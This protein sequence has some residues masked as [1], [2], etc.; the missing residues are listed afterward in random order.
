VVCFFNSVNI[1]N[2]RGDR[3]SIECNDN[4]RVNASTDQ[5]VCASPLIL[6]TE[7][8][9]MCS[10]HGHL[11]IFEQVCDLN[12]L[13]LTAA[14]IIR[15]PQIEIFFFFALQDGKWTEF[16]SFLE[17]E[18]SVA[19]GHHGRLECVCG[20]VFTGFNCDKPCSGHG[21]LR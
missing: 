18:T 21:V 1:T 15:F 2:W 9:V 20:E 13:T 8:E 5:C 19:L 16:E 17:F 6:G 7:C 4:G 3:C 14:F 12:L 10:S 11:F